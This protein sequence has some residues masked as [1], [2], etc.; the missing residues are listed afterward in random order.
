MIGLLKEYL[1]L[2]IEANLAAYEM[3]KYSSRWERFLQKINDREYF[4]DIHGRKFHIFSEE[5][6]ELV[7][8]LMAKKTDDYKRAFKNGVIININGID[9][10]IFYPSYLKKTDDFGSFDPLA[11][12]KEQ[13]I[14]L[15]KSYHEISNG[16]PIKVFNGIE[17]IE[18]NEVK[19]SE[20]SGKADVS[21]LFNGE[22]RIL[23]S[24]KHAKEPY[25]MRQWGGITEFSEHD[26]VKEFVE[27]VKKRIKEK[28]FSKSD[29]FFARFVQIDPNFAAQLCYGTGERQSDLIVLGGSDIR[30]ESVKN[31]PNTFVI[32]ANNVLYRLKRDLPVGPWE[33]VLVAF[34]SA[35]RKNFKIDGFRFG[36]FPIA[37]RKNLR[38]IVINGSV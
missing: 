18:I 27:G 31:R 7:D 22:E 36:C 23:I 1:S 21:L 2:L 6:A 10:I 3:E 11:R 19:K 34:P 4:E 12:E 24:L 29:T 20:I 38:E 5:N 30:F 32:K 37:G 26:L 8:A 9:D 33:P 13:I 25:E 28:T 16:R 17:Y 15:E 35:K 14:S